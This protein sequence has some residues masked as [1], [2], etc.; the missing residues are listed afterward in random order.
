MGRPSLLQKRGWRNIC[1]CEW[2]HF[3]ATSWTGAASP[4]GTSN[5]QPEPSVNTSAPCVQRYARRGDLSWAE[6]NIRPPQPCVASLIPLPSSRK[7][8]LASVYPHPHRTVR[9]PWA[10]VST[11]KAVLAAVLEM[12][13]DNFGYEWLVCSSGWNYR[14]RRQPCWV[15]SSACSEGT[16]LEKKGFLAVLCPCGETTSKRSRASHFWASPQMLFE[17]G[18]SCCQLWWWFSCCV[19]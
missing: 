16:G 19:Y 12:E 4:C 8:R 14:W 9:K 2:P 11:S 6:S 13:P 5:E 17:K 3:L 10:S 18:A 15:R 1:L 7:P